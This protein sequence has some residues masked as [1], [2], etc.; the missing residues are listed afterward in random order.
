MRVVAF[1]LWGDFAHFR[2][3]YTTS[4][5]LT[6]SIP[7]PS[8]LRGLVAAFLGI[9]R[10]EYPKALSVKK[11]RFGVGLLN[12]VK[13]IR[14]GI[15]YLDTKDG[16]WVTL[17]LK[18]LLPVVKKSGNTYRFHTPLRAEF[19]KDPCFEIYFTH[20]DQGLLDELTARLRARR[21]V[22]TPYLGISECLANFE[23]RWD[24]ELELVTGP[25]QIISAFRQD[26]VSRVYIEE[27]VGLVKETLPVFIDEC[28]RRCE[29]VEAVFAPR[30]QALR[31]ELTEAYAYPGHKDLALSFLG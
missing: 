28:R 10:D 12:P 4:S 25:Y 14:L 27:G 20:E 31:V 7:S 8:A 22:F 24:E 3:H 15:N 9:S 29:S 23:F 30:A 5:P 1:K 11:C 2:R 13:K 26:F 19:L 6:H 16:S 21:P 17:D 18:R